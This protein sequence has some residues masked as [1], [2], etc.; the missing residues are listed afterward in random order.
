MKKV[1][2]VSI[3][4]YIWFKHM[5]YGTIDEGVVTE[6]KSDLIKVAIID[7]SYDI[8]ISRSKITDVKKYG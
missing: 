2:N 3:G 8:W 6:I 7:E 4:D 1:F 5:P